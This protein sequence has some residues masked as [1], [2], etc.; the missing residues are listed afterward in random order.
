MSQRTF[1]LIKPDCV[2]VPWVDELEGKGENE[3]GEEIA[4]PLLEQRAPDKSDEILKRVTAAGFTIVEKRLV[5]ITK[6]QAQ[7]FYAEHAGRDFFDKLCDF[8]SSSLSIALV[9]EKDD[10]IASWRALMGPTNSGAAKAAAE[11]EHPLNEELWTLRA[12][13][14]T[15]GTRNA[16]HGSDSA[17]SAAREIEF[18]FPAA[19]RYERTL[20][21]IKP[22]AQAKAD[23]II[24]QIE[25]NNF[26]VVARTDEKLPVARAKAFYAE[27][28]GRPFFDKLVKFMS[29]GTTTALVLER[30]NAI[31]GWRL[32]AGPTD[33][34]KARDSAPQSIRAQF[35]TDGT[36][37][38]VHGSDSIE[39]A[40]REIAFWFPAPLPVERTLALIKPGAADASGTAIKLEA[41][42]YGFT[43][44]AHRR[45]T[46]SEEQAGAFY[47]EHRGKAFFGQLTSYMSSGPI[48][49]L[50][51]SKP[52]AIKC[53]R[54][55]MGPTNSA[56]ARVEAPQSLRARFGTDNTKNATHGSDSP[57][58]AAREIRFF[59]P[60]FRATPLRTGA[61][62]RDFIAKRE[63]ATAF[64]PLGAVPKTLNDVLVEGL[65]ELCKSKP[66]GLEA[67]AWLG[68]WLLENNPRAGRVAEPDGP[69]VVEAADDTA[70][71]ATESK[72]MEDADVVDSKLAEPEVTAAVDAPEK[73]KSIVFVLGAPGCG[74]GTQC[75]R[76]A[77]TY[78]YEHL[79]TGDLLR[80]EVAANTE[81]GRQCAD[82]MKA[83]QL[84]NQDVILALVKKAMARSGSR[85]FLLDGY[86]RSLDQAFE[87]ERQ[88]QSPSFVLNF[89]VSEATATKRILERGKTSG[90]SDDNAATVKKRFATFREQTS[91]AID[92][93]SKLGRVRPV[94]GEG[95]EDAVFA[96]AARAFEPEVVFVLGAPGAGVSTQCSR[97]SSRLGYT[98]L[99]T[100]ELLA[101][102]AATG[103][104]L[105]RDIAATMRRGELV[106]N[107]VTLSLLRR[108]IEDRPN[109][110]FL[111]DGYPRTVEQARSFVAQI[112]EPRFILNL[113]VDPKVGGARVLAAAGSAARADSGTTALAR[114]QRVHA[115]ATAAVLEQY[116]KSGHVRNV[117]ASAGI[118]RVTAECVKA[119]S[120]RIVFVLGG[121]GA[122]KGTQCAKIVQQYGYTHLSAGDLLRAEVARGSPDG[123]MIDSMI[124]SGQIVPVEVT[125]QLLR[126][127]MAASGG[128][129]FLIDGFPRA[130]DQARAFERIVGPC[131][132]VLYFDL[133]EATMRQR[134]LKR[135][136][137]SG[138]A[139]DNEKSIVRRFETFRTTS[140]PVIDHYARLGKVRSVDAR[141][142]PDAV[143]A[144]VQRIFDP[145]VVFVLGGPGSGKG[146][147]CAK[148][149]NEFGYTHLSAGDLLRSEV[150]RGARNA[151][152][153]ERHM[154]SGSLVPVEVTLQLI[155]DAMRASGSSKFLLDGYPRAQDQADAFEAQISKCSFVLFF[156]VDEA[157]MKQRLLQ[158]GK[159]SGRVD[160]NEAAIVKR[161]ATFQETSVP[162]VDSYEAR[163]LVHRIDASGSVD[164][165]YAATRKLF[166]P[167]LALLAGASGSGRGAFA[168]RVGR[169]LGYHRLH[170]RQ[171]LRA[172]AQSGTAMG[173]RIA[174]AMAAGVTAPL[175]ATTAVLRAAI[176]ESSATRFLIDGFPRLVSDGFPGAHDQCYALEEDVG[177]VRGMVV[178]EASVED[179]KA[180]V[181]GAASV[182]DQ[183]ALLRS[184]DT[185]AREKLPVLRF[186][187]AAGKA[188]VVDTTGKDPDAVFAAA[189]SFLA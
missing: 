56:R 52:A 70:G 104:A 17:Y 3:E 159:T 49:A 187:E 30:N 76:L 134:L 32:L 184:V 7:A 112:G 156:D 144:E 148:L 140:M 150:A 117:D 125:L 142:G 147:Q 87:F 123:A 179:R 100:S 26:V 162:V 96:A 136:K 119:A 65:T 153:I 73:E 175:D 163:G 133:D 188:L 64:T 98:H 178:L 97:L 149:V 35:G 152:M 47:A 53:W 101:A 62:A 22:D 9:L 28:A 24:A 171:L 161:F 4:V 180:R 108:A 77:K 27:H 45:L 66:T 114:R 60:Q 84:V 91:A 48:E 34:S 29:S 127:A 185:F 166:Q 174:Q 55:L 67:V 177:P 16:V 15:D 25:A 106:P 183:A 11:A 124:R 90:R 13:F 126:T 6:A 88:V 74:K 155:K 92:F 110:R 61:D 33:T 143:F 79:S 128:D 95:S 118:D 18:F 160:D 20:A 122:G 137:T 139:D 2:G 135:G 86:P 103:S 41:E 130:M 168:E 94:D 1:A 46:L 83:G 173:A 5:Q 72:G 82:V 71:G 186:Y 78:G 111:I 69:L 172:E 39:S 165:V 93:Y 141:G 145:R 89:E 21:L 42:A 115:T 8:M 181:G 12:L 44:L 10:A 138:R 43:I 99:S 14:G 80:A 116:S 146:T 50:V 113:N 189:Q 151:S 107:D 158:R 31:A 40:A 23:E 164:A 51:L 54:A 38:A 68:N 131:D 154:A 105:G 132:F 170:A 19:R 75:Q 129:R 121:P 176:N 59:F 167:E 182:G 37:N 63:V 102:E 36:K 57:A 169:Q 81:L 120:P 109:Q 85:R 58:S 157:T